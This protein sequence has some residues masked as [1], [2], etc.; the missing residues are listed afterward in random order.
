MD[1]V[2]LISQIMSFDIML[3]QLI[4]LR[5]NII[6]ATMIDYQDIFMFS[7]FLFTIGGCQPVHTGERICNRECKCLVASNLRC[8][9]LG[10]SVTLHKISCIGVLPFVDQLNQVHQDRLQKLWAEVKLS[11]SIDFL[12]HSIAHR[13]SRP[14]FTH[15]GPVWE[16]KG[17]SFKFQYS[18]R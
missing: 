12:Y 5:P 16:M 13:R 11:H 18:K 9:I 6:L 4:K 8:H 2:Q 10:P 3:F 17:F 1:S 14:A 7:C 15:K